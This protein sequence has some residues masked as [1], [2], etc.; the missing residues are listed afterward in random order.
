MLNNPLNKIDSTDII[1]IITVTLGVGSVAG[2]L[3][4]S[5]AGYAFSDVLYTFGAKTEITLGLGA[6]LAG[7]VYGVATNGLT[8]DQFEDMS[9]GEQAAVAITGALVVVMVLSPD[10]ASF[11]QDSTVAGGVVTFAGLVSSAVIA[12]E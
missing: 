1:T 6:A 5:A 3:D 9:Q 8:R 11:V 7:L 2:F 12:S 4:F 10:L